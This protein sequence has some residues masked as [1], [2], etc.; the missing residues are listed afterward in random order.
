MRFSVGV[1]LL[2]Q[3]HMFAYR[4]ECL[5]EVSNYVFDQWF[6]KE[7]IP[8]KKRAKQTNKRKQ[9]SNVS[10]ENTDEAQPE[11]RAVGGQTEGT[12]A[13]MHIAQDNVN[14]E[15]SS[16]ASLDLHLEDQTAPRNRLP[17]DTTMISRHDIRELMSLDGRATH[18]N[19][20]EGHPQHASHW[21]AFNVT[22]R[23]PVL[24]PVSYERCGNRPKA[25][26]IRRARS[27]DRHCCTRGRRTANN[28]IGIT[29]W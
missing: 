1:S 14:S 25:F 4:P 3:I 24:K 12:Y 8:K 10:E 2:M 15:P 22:R 6:H 28:T 20:R 23:I 26:K 16:A 27:L 17:Q 7:S 21:L 11:A 13:D 5:S 18:I 19:F 29:A 9:T